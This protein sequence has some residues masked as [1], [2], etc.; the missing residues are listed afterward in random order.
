MQI[1]SGK[2]RTSDCRPADHAVVNAGT[3]EAL[4]I[5]LDE[6]SSRDPSAPQNGCLRLIIRRSS[7]HRD[8]APWQ[9]KFISLRECWNV[10]FVLA[11]FLSSQTD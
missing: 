2:S 11:A 10:S 3:V 4:V 6:W 5:Q 7:P 9:A 1:F 8:S